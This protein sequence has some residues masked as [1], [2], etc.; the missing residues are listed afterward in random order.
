MPKKPNFRVER[1]RGID[2]R[3]IADIESPSVKPAG[4]GLRAGSDRLEARTDSAG[5]DFAGVDIVGETVAAGFGPT[6]LPMACNSQMFLIGVQLS[7][8]VVLSS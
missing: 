3:K 8:C 5:P 7:A 6:V 1:R 2:D 4:K